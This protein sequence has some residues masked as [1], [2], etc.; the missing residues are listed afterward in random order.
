MFVGLAVC[1][2]SSVKMIG[3]VNLIS[4][5]NV[6]SS[7]NYE[8]LKTGV[9]DS[10]KAW[11]QTKSKNLDKAINSAVLAVPGGEFL[12]NCKIYTDGKYW[13]VMGDV[14]GLSENANVNGF[15]IGDPVFVSNGILSKDKFT[16]GT[17]AGFKDEK[18]CLVRYDGGEIKEVNYSDLSKTNE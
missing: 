18:S 6:D 15:K 1:S 3:D 10:R 5:R 16:P 9:D 4:T 7:A 14:Y 2:C 17:I 8:L 13:A 12:K 11:K